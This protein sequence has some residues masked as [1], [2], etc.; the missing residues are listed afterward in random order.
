MNTSMVLTVYGHCDNI[1]DVSV[2]TCSYPECGRCH[3]IKYCSRECLV[4]HWPQHKKLC[5]SNN[6]NK[7]RRDHNKLAT[8]VKSDIL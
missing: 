1:E 5:S 6:I 8:K 4:A 7:I 3:M 2:L